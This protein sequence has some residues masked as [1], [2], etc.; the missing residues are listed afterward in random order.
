MDYSNDD[1]ARREESMD[2]LI[3]QVWETGRKFRYLET[4]PLTFPTELQR[5]IAFCLG[6]SR[7]VMNAGFDNI[8]HLK[9][10]LNDSSDQ[11][12]RHQLLNNGNFIADGL[13]CEIVSD[14]QPSGGHID[15]LQPQLEF[16]RLHGAGAPM[17]SMK[18][19]KTTST[20]REKLYKI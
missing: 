12:G 3:G 18:L 1:S 8:A 20:F 10:Y 6:A 19:L 5:A 4:N 9:K 13:L 7:Q 14:W 2:D 17:V 11:A 16:I 15:S